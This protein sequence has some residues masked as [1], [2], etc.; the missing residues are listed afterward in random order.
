MRAIEVG[1]FF[2]ASQK[3]LLWFPWHLVKVVGEIMVLE[4]LKS[5]LRRNVDDVMVLLM[6]LSYWQFVHVWLFLFIQTKGGIITLTAC[7]L[8]IVSIVEIV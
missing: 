5:L 7:R 8:V 6:S 2:L 1:N 4:T 3:H